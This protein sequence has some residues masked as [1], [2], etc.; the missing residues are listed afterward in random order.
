M[1]LWQ[2]FGNHINTSD[3][4]KSLRF[5]KLSSE[6]LHYKEICKNNLL[7]IIQRL[8]GKKLMWLNYVKWNKAADQTDKIKDLLVYDDNCR[9]NYR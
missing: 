7:G 1:F 8:F 3:S 4:S 5:I 2:S 6:I 9:A